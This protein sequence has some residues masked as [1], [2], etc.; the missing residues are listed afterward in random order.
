[1]LLDV[2]L[3]GLVGMLFYMIMEQ[4]RLTK[5]PMVVVVKDRSDQ[6]KDVA[7]G[8]STSDLEASNVESEMKE[9]KKEKKDEKTSP[10]SSSSKDD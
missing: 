2:L 8:K 3:G 7:L 4:W 5:D 10:K 6:D 1:M 9:M